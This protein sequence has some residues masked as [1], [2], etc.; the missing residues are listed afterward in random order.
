MVAGGAA[1]HS[2]HGRCVAEVF[3]S[4]A[5]KESDAY[6]IKDVPKLLAVAKNLGVATTVEVDGETKD[7]DMDEIAVETAE[8]ALNEWGK[9]EGELLYT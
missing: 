3:M 2:D 9:A 4:A 6:K 5:R 7:R 1:A 8:I